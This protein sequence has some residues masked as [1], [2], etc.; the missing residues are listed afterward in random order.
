M[1]GASIP[2]DNASPTSEDSKNENNLNIILPLVICSLL[3]LS[4]IITTFFHRRQELDI[5]R[6][7]LERTRRRSSDNNQNSNVK[8]SNDNSKPSNRNCSSSEEGLNSTNSTDLTR[9]F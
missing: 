8:V 9:R 4:I 5:L 2:V 1:K 3:V 6:V 7:A